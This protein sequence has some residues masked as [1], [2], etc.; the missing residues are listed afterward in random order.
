M[1]KKILIVDDEE[2]VRLSLGFWLRRHD[3]DVTLCG[4]LEDARQAL[5]RE[6]FDYVI[7]DFR[8]TPRGEEGVALLESA[9]ATNP[10][11]KRI[12]VTATPAHELPPALRASG[13]FSLY[14][15]P[16]DV[17]ELLQVLGGSLT[18]SAIAF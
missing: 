10:A 3:F 8:L 6:T 17:F 12:M 9:R 2:S 5:E 7:S 4:R 13:L 14:H 15:K 1:R 18:A 16:I 11:A